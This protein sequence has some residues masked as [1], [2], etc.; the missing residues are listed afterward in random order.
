MICNKD[1]LFFSELL[2]EWDGGKGDRRQRV[3]P[4]RREQGSLLKQPPEGGWQ[5]ARPVWLTMAQR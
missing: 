5:N 1:K 4:V 2:A 3:C